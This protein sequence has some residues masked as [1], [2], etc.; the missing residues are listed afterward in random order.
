MS[1][2][3]ANRK[4]VAQTKLWPILFLMLLASAYTDRTPSVA[5]NIFSSR[6]PARIARMTVPNNNPN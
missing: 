5:N 2:R 1:V 6:T 3:L 4:C